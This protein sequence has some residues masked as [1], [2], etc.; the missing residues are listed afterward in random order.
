MK[1][2]PRRE[3]LFYSA[4]RVLKPKIRTIKP[5]LQWECIDRIHGGESDYIVGI[6]QATLPPQVMPLPA[7]GERVGELRD[8]VLRKLGSGMAL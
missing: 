7:Y 3:G 8:D 2:F 1:P 5:L 4:W 6:R